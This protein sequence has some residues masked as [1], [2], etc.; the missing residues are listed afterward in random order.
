M[1]CSKLLFLLTLLGSFTLVSGQKASIT[2]VVLGIN[3]EPLSNVNIT[4]KGH[5]TYTDSTGFYLLEVIPDKEITII[6]THL[7]HKNVILENLILSTNETF[8]FNPVMKTD[9]IQVDGVEVTATGE[10]SAEG[11]TTISAKLVRK[12]PGANAGV[13]N[14]LKLLPGVSSNNELS[15]Q[16]FVRGGNYDENLVYI[17]DIEVYRPFLVR[18]GQQEGLSF[19]NSDMVQNL[20]FS[21]GGFQAHYG[22]KL[23]SVLDITYK[24]PTEFGLN[25][26]ASFLGGGIT[27]ETL[28]ENKNFTS[29]TGL[30]YRN[31]S[32][33]VNSQQTNT[34][35][36]PAF[37]DLQTYL[38]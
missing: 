27:L 25:L 15:T 6:F 36:T 11:I 5:G 26:E 8:E 4:T 10:K 29:V 28:S 3:D 13:E 17:N 37:A 7:G 30:R 21:A 38:T 23:S 2:G 9:V 19:V 24:N 31:N 33:L 20:E 14:V 35:F 18:S 22:D 12:I 16:Y 34:N 32:L 1:K